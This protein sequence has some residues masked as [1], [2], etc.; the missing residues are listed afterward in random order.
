MVEFFAVIIL[1][2][3]LLVIMIKAGVGEKRVLCLK[4]HYTGTQKKELVGSFAME[5]FLWL[6][7]IIPGFFYSIW[8][9]TNKRKVCPKCKSVDVIPHDSPRAAEILTK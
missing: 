3:I 4:C 1:V 2:I 5:A 6:L 7:F 8:R 9:L